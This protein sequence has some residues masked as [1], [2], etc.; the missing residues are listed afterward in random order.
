MKVFLTL[1][2]LLLINV[3]CIGQNGPTKIGD[4]EIGKTTVEDVLNLP[5]YGYKKPFLFIN[6]KLWKHQLSSF[7]LF[8]HWLV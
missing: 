7:T 1:F 2:I 6:K 8:A 3:N 4:F 5:Y